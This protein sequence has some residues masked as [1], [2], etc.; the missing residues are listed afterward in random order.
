MEGSASP[1]QCHCLLIPSKPPSCSRSSSSLQWDS[2]FTLWK[3]RPVPRSMIVSFYLSKLPHA[4]I[5]NSNVET[6]PYRREVKN[7]FPLFQAQSRPYS[8]IVTS[9]PANLSP[10]Q[11]MIFTIMRL[12]YKREVKEES[13]PLCKVRPLPCSMI[14]SSYPSNLSHAQFII[15]NI[16]TLPYRREVLCRAWRFW[17]PNLPL[18]IPIN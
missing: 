13:F 6:L 8:M 17:V 3:A 9:Y 4:Q 1:V 12:P 14:V 10:A 18:C 7:P 11:I 2:S 16:M 15:S 5:N